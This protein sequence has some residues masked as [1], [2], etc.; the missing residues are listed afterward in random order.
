MKAAAKGEVV[1]FPTTTYG[2]GRVCSN[3]ERCVTEGRPTVLSRF[4][5]GPK[6]YCCQ[7]REKAERAAH[8]A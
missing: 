5:P 6:C 8:A 7:A 4:N 2:D 3:F 1:V